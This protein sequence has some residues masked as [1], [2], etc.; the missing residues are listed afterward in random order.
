MFH[1]N[2]LE[3]SSPPIFIIMYQRYWS[4]SHILHQVQKV[5]DHMLSTNVHNIPELR[6]DIIDE[7]TMIIHFCNTCMSVM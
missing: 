6:Q 2:I 5:N 7:F 4:S 1:N 3:L